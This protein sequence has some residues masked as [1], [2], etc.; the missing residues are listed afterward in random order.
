LAEVES[1][2]RINPDQLRRGGEFA[3]GMIRIEAPIDSVARWLGVHELDHL[4]GHLERFPRGG[5]PLEFL[6]PGVPW[7]QAVSQYKKLAGEVSAR[8]AQYRLLS[9]SEK[10]RR[11]K[12]P[13]STQEIPW[14]QQII[15]YY[16]EGY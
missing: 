11:M 8:D 6:K 5:A 9:L 10:Q 15:R 3:P 14:D 13:P 2:I 4:V 1:R 12:S 16:P 7:E